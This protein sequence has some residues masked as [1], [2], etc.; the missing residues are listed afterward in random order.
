MPK[1]HVPRRASMQFW[2][3]KRASRAYARVRSWSGHVKDCKP[4][5]FAGYKV[6]MTHVT[7]IDNAPNSMTK[8]LEVPMPVTIIEC[9]PIK[10]LSL[11]FYKKI[12]NTTKIV[13]EVMAEKPD[14]ELSRKISVPKSVKKKIGDIKDFDEIRLVV[15]TQPKLT[16]IGKKKPEIFEIALSGSKEEQLNL[17]KEKLGKEIA[18]A[19]I[20][21]PGSLVDVHSVTKGK[22]FQGPM[23]R[24]GI[25]LT[26]HKAEK[27]RRNPGSLGGWKGQGHFMYR[28][29]HAG[30]TGY[31]QRIDYNKQL[32]Q[33][34][35]NPKSVN[36]KSGIKHYGLAK[37]TIIMVKGSVPGAAKRLIILT[38]AIRPDPKAH[39]EAP[40]VNYIKVN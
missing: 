38:H 6:G 33:I 18:I 3:R 36:P 24:F 13:S 2:P 23:K 35:D 12:N 39:L 19:E 21:A 7:F 26:S 16:G 20:F 22:G 30:Q 1:P 25:S 31:H 29:A 17:A 34:L 11:R 27:A 5:G 9:P 37:N 15:H 4:L 10:T 8:G 28:V 32:V 40:N 14:K